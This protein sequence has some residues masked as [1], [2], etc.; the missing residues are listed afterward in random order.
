MGFSI[1]IGKMELFFT[2]RK[3]FSQCIGLI[4]STQ[5][6][7]SLMIFQPLQIY[8]PLSKIDPNKSETAGGYWYFLS[9]QLMCFCSL[10][11]ATVTIIP[12]L[13][14]ERKETAKLKEQN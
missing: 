8:F 11:A 1:E 10:I 2:H 9:G 12:I 5:I 14:L 6:L 13:K 4:M 3:I 7:G